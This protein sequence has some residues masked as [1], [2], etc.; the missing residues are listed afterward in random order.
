MYGVSMG[1]ANNGVAVGD[2]GTIVYTSD[3]GDTWTAATTTNAGS[4]HMQGVS[5]VDANN[6]VAVG[7]SGTIVFVDITSPTTVITSSSGSTGSTIADT[8]L[9]Y[10]VTFS[11]SVS[12][13]VVGDI[14][15]T[16]TA[17]SGSPAASNFAGS[18]ATYTFDVVKGSSDGTVVV[19]VAAGTA[20][21]AAGNDNI[22]SNTYT[23]T[24]DTV[25]PT[26]AIT[27][28][29]S[30]CDS[31]ISDTTLSYTVTFSESVSNFVVGDIT[32]TGTAN[33]GS[34][35]ASNFAGSG[36]TYTFDVVRGSSDGTVVVSVAAGTATDVSNNSNIVS[37][38]CTLTIDTVH[39]IPT[40][41]SSTDSNGSTVSDLTL[42]YIVTFSKPVSNFVVGDITVTGTANSGSPAASNF[43]GSGT[44]YTFDVVKGSSDGIVVVSVA[45]NTTTDDSDNDNLASNVYTMTIDT[46][47]SSD[48]YDCEPPKLTRVEVHV[49]SNNSDNLNDGSLP[50]ISETRDYVWIV[51]TSTELPVFGSHMTPIIA[52]PGDEIEIVMVITD[53][54][55]LKRFIDAGSYTNFKE[56]PND[57]NLFYANNFD[58]FGKVSTTFYEWNKTGDDLIYDYSESV[59]WQP[60]DV[61]IDEYFDSEKD[62]LKNDDYL[63]GT[64]TI[65]FKMKFLQPMDTTELWV[66]A[67]D[68][69]GNFFKVALPLT[70]KVSGNEPL[71]FESKVNQKVLSFYDEQKFIEIVSVWNGSSQDVSQLESLLGI[72]DQELPPW[73]ANLALWVSEGKITPGDMIVSI[74][75]L[76]NN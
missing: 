21:D 37:N 33:S 19:S 76:I 69:S 34:P 53:N 48:C 6:G 27:S 24:I 28:N 44:T 46:G 65:S 50:L 26:T 12:N 36:A 35:A 41:T 30:S 38:T 72:S 47:T 22:A 52:D 64:F 3:G 45:A 7:N 51:D 1:D 43:T 20:T 25:N 68:G 2:S 29:T 62:S 5:M 61:T 58:K 71:V 63:I 31:T 10:T 15:V 55:T 75:H 74:E 39:P 16:G 49:T 14:T 42:S 57:M 73:V 40:I 59:K 4:N 67:T 11:E 54:R 9:S 8:T 60:S 70:L 32:V 56:R 18:G 13:F 17:N 23:L 66:Q